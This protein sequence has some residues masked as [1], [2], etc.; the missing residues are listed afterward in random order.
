[1]IS[2]ER[3][4]ASALE[5]YEKVIDF[6]GEL[7]LKTHGVAFSPETI[8]AWKHANLLIYYVDKALDSGLVPA[9]T[10]ANNL[11][12]IF[13]PVSCGGDRN[14]ALG[15]QALAHGL[16]LRNSISDEQS[17]IF[18]RK[19]L[20]IM[21]VC[22][23]WRET[24][25]PKEYAR[26]ARLIGQMQAT[27]FLQIVTPND[28]RQANFRDFTLFFR[29]AGRLSTGIDAIADIKA[30]YDEGL[31]SV[32]PSAK[33]RL[34]M[35]RNM[36]PDIFEGVKEIGLSTSLNLLFRAARQIVRDRRRRSSRC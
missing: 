10:V 6:S 11:R 22:D 35:A 34:M 29:H 9:E 26:K 1:M 31:V 25:D 7:A 14:M 2:S 5:M 19:G 16:A 20:Q 28:R 21:K 36:A 3:L 18:L 12:T 4:E 27:M 24:Q 13:G 15:D 17:D 32:E 30:D 8:T 23:S 33:N